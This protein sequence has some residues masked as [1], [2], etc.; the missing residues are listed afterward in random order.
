MMGTV[1]LAI[2]MGSRPNGGMADQAGAGAL[3]PVGVRRPIGPL[4]GP[5]EGHS[6]V[7]ELMLATR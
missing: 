2:T 1:Y 3:E 7:R 5:E 4:D 6:V